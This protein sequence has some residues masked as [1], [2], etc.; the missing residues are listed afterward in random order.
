MGKIK[1]RLSDNCITHKVLA[2]AKFFFAVSWSSSQKT[3]FLT[4]QW[5]KETNCTS[6][7]TVLDNC[8]QTWGRWKLVSPLST[9]HYHEHFNITGKNQPS[10][11]VAGLP[12]SSTVFSSSSHTSSSSAAEAIFLNF[13]QEKAN[14]SKLTKSSAQ[15]S[16]SAYFLHHLVDLPA[17]ARR[18]FVFSFL[19]QAHKAINHRSSLRGL[20]TKE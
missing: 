13:S 16:I 10:F 9:Y 20:V 8:S 12:S 4:L 5:E 18:S 6:Q 17:N 3:T 1:W 15:I 19:P 11:K 7:W 2:L 14:K